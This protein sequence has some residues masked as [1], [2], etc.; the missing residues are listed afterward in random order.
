[1]IIPI[2]TNLKTNLLIY[3]CSV[4]FVLPTATVWISAYIFVKVVKARKF[5]FPNSAGSVFTFPCDIGWHSTQNTKF[6]DSCNPQ[7]F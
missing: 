3:S 6:L 1:M 5:P 4:P 2:L 7:D